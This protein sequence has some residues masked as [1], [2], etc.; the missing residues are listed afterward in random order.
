M[1]TGN[2]GLTGGVQ[3]QP[4]FQAGIADHQVHFAADVPRFVRE[5]MADYAGLTGRAY[6]PVMPYRCEDAETAIVGLGSV[7]CDLEAVVDHLRTQGR[8]AGSV[9]LKLLQPFPEAEL[10]A[11]LAGKRAITVLERSGVTALTSLVTQALSKARENASGAHHAGIPAIANPPKIV[12]AV[13][14]LGGH[15]L[16]PRHLVAAFDNMDATDSAPFVYL[17]TQFFS[18]NPG[19]R[20]GEIQAKLK[21]A[22]P[23]TAFM[24]LETKDNPN[25]LPEGA[26]R[27][28]FHS[29]G[30]YGTI[31]T[32]KLLT[33][34]LAG[35]LNLYSKSAPK[36]GSEKSGAPTNFYI[37]L[38]PEPV[39]ITNA[40]IED[41]EIAISPD[42][43]VFAHSNP[44]RGLVPGGVFIL[45]TGKTPLEAWRELPDEARKT[46]REKAIQFYVIDAFAVAK[47]HAP[48]PELQ[49][50]MMGI[51]FIGALCGNI[52][53]IAAGSDRSA[54]LEKIREQIAAKFGGKGG[55]IVEG[56]MA[57]IREGLEATVKVAYDKPE[58][59]AAGNGQEVKAKR[60]VD[61]SAAMCRI[62]KEDSAAGLF[63]REYYE[64]IAMR[65]FR[66]GSIGEAPV[67][68]G[69]GLFIPGGTG[70]MK[71]KGLF[72]RNVPSFDAS[73]CTGC[74][75]CSLMCP[76]AALP[77]TVHE[78]SDLLAAA[79]EQTGTAGP[80]RAALEAKTGAI[81]SA[82]RGIYI[83]AN[84]YKALHDVFAEA[85]ATAA[86][87]AT[88]GE[89]DLADGFARMT[90]ALA[91]FPAVRT[92]LFFEQMEKKQPG[93]GGLYSV[94]LD[95][96]KC[97]GCLECM[98]VCSSGALSQT[99][100]TEAVLEKLQTR[101]EFL[102]KTANTPARFTGKL[103]GPNAKWLILDR[104]NYYATTGGHGACRGCGE[105]TAIRQVMAAAHAIHQ[106][107]RKAE[108]AELEQLIAGLSEKLASTEDGSEAK[109]RI[110][111][112]LDALEK[113][114]YRLES[115]PSGQGAAGAVIVNATGCSSV[116]SSTFPFTQYRDPWVNSLFQDA[117]AVAK[118]VFEGICADAVD[119]FRA[120]RI[121]ELELAGAYDPKKD[122]R[123][124]RYFGW[125]QFSAKEL[126]RLPAVFSL[127]G[128]GANYD[129]GFGALSRLLATQAPVK[130]VV[131]NTGSYS[132][133][134]GQASTSSFTGQDSDLARV[135]SVH[136]GKQEFRK[137]LGLIAAFHPKVMVVQTAVGLQ[138]HFLKNVLAALTHNSSPVLID[139]YTPCQGEQGIGD[140]VSSSH[141]RLA[142]ESRMN[143]VFVYNPTQG[144]HLRDWFSLDGNPD[145][146]QDWTML[147]LEFDDE[148][149]AVQT[150]DVP[151]T[152]AHFAHWE[153]RFKKQFHG[154]PLAAGTDGVPV[155]EYIDLAPAEREGKVPFIYEAHGRK[156][157]R[158]EVSEVI[159]SLVRERR[160]HW[161]ILRS[162]AG[163]DIEK[164]EQEYLLEIEKLRC[165]TAPA[166]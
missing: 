143:P 73:K 124:L 76:D 71:D 43:K 15:D 113:R 20:L 68:P 87:T 9:A 46:I 53:R 118:G 110:G 121:A 19:P 96:W 50:R 153:G 131:L 65:P 84:G 2:P 37:T 14:G 137:E 64:D 104:E 106:K 88:D 48:T 55:A 10:A 117:P 158:Y 13:F 136:T 111:Q 120:V 59:I 29:I 126:A 83:A 67:L 128:D 81:A 74:L 119:D 160:R 26:F 92:R 52:G 116:Y 78:I 56:N 18:K 148:N 47:R 114:L 125:E 25:L 16:Q 70:A 129:I 132:N 162:L 1:D 142:V 100:Q 150:M 36:Y 146:D 156:L 77:S 112:T 86:A 134:G 39:K 3:N 12:T 82:M 62:A 141:A 33:D 97:S 109:A 154:K 45:Q 54:V 147:T 107:E 108:I 21:A 72:R 75:E 101:F 163:Q 69:S 79:L 127:G 80:R 58:F 89:A 44:L 40:E 35:L 123:K 145:E 6:A 157:V 11:A 135:G 85:A 4:D 149:G 60:T 133:T 41:V 23:E 130:A 139:I 152:P 105:A 32:G 7:A 98:A 61:L 151:L 17:G 49:T 165:E 164:L 5:A 66:E 22:Y 28:R 38:S 161:R 122:G 102:T 34:I 42:H 24:A 8:K 115:G 93:S 144:A 27:V 140:S 166:E 31:A 57:V 159:V 94:V 138:G 91:A 63:G 90:G 103:K 99:V 155:D 95:P 51:A 30:G